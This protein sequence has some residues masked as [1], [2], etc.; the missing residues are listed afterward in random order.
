M[1]IVTHHIT[2]SNVLET[3][4]MYYLTGGDNWNISE[5]HV[6]ANGFFQPSFSMRW[7]RTVLAILSLVAYVALHAFNA[8]LYATPRLE[9]FRS[10]VGGALKW[11]AFDVYTSWMIICCLVSMG[12]FLLLQRL[13]VFG[14]IVGFRYVD[15]LI[16]T[17][18]YIAV[19][20]GTVMFV[21]M[22]LY[23]GITTVSNKI[24]R[25]ISE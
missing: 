3:E 8:D 23:A 9:L 20:P 5:Y 11:K 7:Q 1:G 22:F 18:Y 16:V 24:K 19:I 12:Y 17:M 6:A 14:N 13:D 15:T 10:D 25:F 4:D 21:C 2:D